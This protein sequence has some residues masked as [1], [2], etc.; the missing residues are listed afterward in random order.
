MLNYLLQDF[1]KDCVVMVT[2]NV[3]TILTNTLVN[4][5]QMYPKIN[6]I[7]CKYAN[8]SF[9]SLGSNLSPYG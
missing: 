7:L 2:V 4:E 3:N 5:I 8:V 1:I 9:S 6:I